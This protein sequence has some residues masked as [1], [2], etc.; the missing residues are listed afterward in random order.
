VY[1]LEGAEVA[2][3]AWL[4]ATDRGRLHHAWMLAGPE[5]VGK[6]TFAYRAARRLL[7]GRPAQDYGL[8]G[9]SPDDPVSRLMESRS[10]PD[11]LVLERE[12]EDGKLKRGISVDEARR[13]PEFFAKSPSIAAWRVAIIDAADDLNGAAANAVLKTLEEP[14]ER[15][16]VLMVSHSPGAL[17]PTLRSRCRKLR[18]P[19]WSDARVANFVAVATGAAASDAQRLAG[20]SCGAPGRA[21]RLEAQGALELDETARAL[22]DTA[23]RQDALVQGLADKMKGGEAAARFSLLLELLSEQARALALTRAETAPAEAE[24]LAAVWARW[25]GL[26]GEVDGLNLDR[27]EALWSV[28]AD[29]RSVA[30]A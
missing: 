26:P 29:I 15:G 9:A 28:A 16:V 5:G 25:R 4:T 30:A 14:P 7:G 10:H 17:L 2:E 3:Q 13:L 20:L 8:L 19:R 21:L 6:A 22:F 12:G 24:R 23:G 18:F 11:L 1:T 27:A